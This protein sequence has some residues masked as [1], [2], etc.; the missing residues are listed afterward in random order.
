MLVERARDL[1]LVSGT[2]GD[3]MT[4]TAVHHATTLSCDYCSFRSEVLLALRRTIGIQ[5][6]TLT[7]R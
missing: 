3:T 1:L 5:S 6:R 7:Q 2:T 4:T